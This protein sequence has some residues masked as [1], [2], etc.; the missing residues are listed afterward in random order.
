MQQTKFMLRN[1]VCNVLYSICTSNTHQSWKWMCICIYSQYIEIQH[2][3]SQQ[4]HKPIRCK[5][6]TADRNTKRCRLISDDES[7]LIVIK[8]TH[9]MSYGHR[10]MIIFA[11]TAVWTCCSSIH[12]MFQQS[13]RKV[14]QPNK[15][16]TFQ[17]PGRVETSVWI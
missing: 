3:I 10:Y 13:T 9:W 4:R 2:L 17:V 6:H 1:R 8:S 15:I 5:L 14:P 7:S 16:R 11:Y 12:P